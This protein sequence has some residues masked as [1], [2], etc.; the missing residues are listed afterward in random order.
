MI[1]R[2]AGINRGFSIPVLVEGRREV[3]SNKDKADRL[4]VSS[5]CTVV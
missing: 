3:V 4:G 5:K 1:H 2:M